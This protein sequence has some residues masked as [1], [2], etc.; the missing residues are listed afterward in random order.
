MEQVQRDTRLSRGRDADAAAARGVD[1]TDRGRGPA[2]TMSRDVSAFAGLMVP[3]SLALTR[4]VS[5]PF[6]GLTATVGI[7]PL[8][9][10][11]TGVREP[12]ALFRRLGRPN[13]GDRRKDQP[14]PSQ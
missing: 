9:T 10:S 12:A 4:P 3:M 1:V 7:N 14:C 11:V 5:L 8:Q 13:A 6:P 2:M